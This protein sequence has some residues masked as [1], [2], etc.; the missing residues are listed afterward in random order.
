MTFKVSTVGDISPKFRDL[1][2]EIF[3]NVSRS[4]RGFPPECYLFVCKTDED[5]LKIK[6]Q[7]INDFTKNHGLGYI[8]LPNVVGLAEA[9]LYDSPEVVVYEYGVKSFLRTLEDYE[10]LY[11]HEGGHLTYYFNNN[12][13]SVRKAMPLLTFCVDR[14]KEDYEAE[15][16]AIEADY[17]TA[18]FSR[19]YTTIVNQFRMPEVIS[20]ISFMDKLS[21]MGVHAAFMKSE[22]PKIEQKQKIQRAW[23][24]FSRVNKSEISK[25]LLQ[26][27]ELKE[28]PGLFGD[29]RFFKD[30][31]FRKHY[32]W[33]IS[34]R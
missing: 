32:G 13:L 11:S 23:N 10:G 33:N 5:C 22:K 1:T 30:F 20:P 2:V 18:C 29:E 31:I 28:S 19:Q 3:D 24:V 14:V 21:L 12:L 17:Y 34:F 27:D 9:A 6:S 7:R 8:R 4:M 25:S 15:K 16:K 26:S